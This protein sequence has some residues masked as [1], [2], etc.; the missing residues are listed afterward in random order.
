MFKT[1]QHLLPLITAYYRFLLLGEPFRRL[2]KEPILN[3]NCDVKVLPRKPQGLLR[4]LLQKLLQKLLQ[5][6]RS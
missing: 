2:S 6:K 5:R 3:V 1:S 4:E